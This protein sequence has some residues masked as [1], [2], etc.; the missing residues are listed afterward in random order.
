MLEHQ[1]KEAQ[2][3]IKNRRF[4]LFLSMC[5]VV[6]LVAGTIVSCS[7]KS[8][9]SGTTT[10]T[11]A[12]ASSS[13]AKGVASLNTDDIANV[14]PRLKNVVD[15]MVGMLQKSGAQ[16][17]RS[18]AAAFKASAFKTLSSAPSISVTDWPCDVSGTFSASGDI[19]T[20][21]TSTTWTMAITFHDCKDNIGFDVLNGTLTAIHTEDTVNGNESAQVTANLVDTDYDVS[22]TITGTYEL[23][24][25]FECVKSG[26]TGTSSAL[27]SFTWTDPGTNGNTVYTFT[28]GTDGSAVTDIWTKTTGTNGMTT[29]N[30]GNG[31]YSLSIATP[32][33]SV[34]LTVML[35]G[36]EYKVLSYTVGGHTDEWLNGAINLA[37]TPD[38]SQ[39]GCMA[40]TYTFTTAPG[41]PIHTL[42]GIGCPT[43]GTLQVNNATIEYGK[44]SGTQVTVTIGTLSETFASCNAMGSGLCKE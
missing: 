29:T 15:K 11:Q 27:G 8:G 40:G 30:T 6:I 42:F 23:N 10:T 2:K 9:D 44:P 28:F 26:M 4:V 21:G 39:W 35:T 1:K 43:S 33:E 25:S 3:M 16:S 18:Q 36:L 20:S 24:G 17:S 38:L 7:S 22:S 32:S 12:A 13:A 19:S 14:D 34:T 41:T 5:A 31:A 37:W